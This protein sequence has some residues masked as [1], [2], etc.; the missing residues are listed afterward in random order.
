MWL[1][2]FGSALTFLPLLF[3]T[4]RPPSRRW[5][6]VAWLSGTCLGVLVLYVAT[7]SWSLTG[8][9]L[10]G[11]VEVAGFAPLLL[12]LLACGLASAA[13]LV[14]R[15][16][17]SRREERQQLKWF[18]LAVCGLVVLFVLDG[19]Q[20]PVG[21]GNALAVILIPCIPAAV[22]VGM[23]RYRLYDIDRIIN[24]TLVYGALTA[25]LG[26]LY[27]GAVV[28]LQ[29]A[30]GERIG[31]SPLA[32]AATTL[33]VA[34]LF[35]PARALVQT[36][37]DRRFNRSTYDA[38]KTVEAFSGRLRDEVDLDQLS[39]DLVA[40]ARTTMQPAHASLWLRPAG[41]TRELPGGSGR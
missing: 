36:L 9:Q 21:A 16:R 37:I 7:G 35:R 8:K 2:G 39:S 1:P 17:A 19:L 40:V 25:F 34:A 22:G 5:R 10:L 4:G 6:P 29:A 26:A 23:L 24:R 31:S 32:V 28:V 41:E 20:I 27:S 11:E 33:A 15:F 30:V 12:L 38:Q 3:P 13:S 14:A 18:V